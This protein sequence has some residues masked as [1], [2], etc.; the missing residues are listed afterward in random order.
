MTGSV[1]LSTNSIFS[2]HQPP[3]VNYASLWTWSEGKCVNLSFWLTSL[4]SKTL[5]LKSGLWRL[6]CYADVV[7]VDDNIQWVVEMCPMKH[8]LSIKSFEI[9]QLR[10]DGIK[11]NFE[12]L[13]SSSLNE[14]CLSKAKQLYE[15]LN[16]LV[17]NLDILYQ[18]FLANVSPITKWRI[19][20]IWKG[21]EYHLRTNAV[22]V[23]L[24]LYEKANLFIKI[25]FW[26][27]LQRT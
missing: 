13:Q 17:F 7:W 16:Y 12:H 15:L 6:N 26:K 22:K 14:K 10:V 9:K 21:I 18:Y 20:L 24:W 19:L 1:F 3:A 27:F 8:I 4:L 2:F 11:T 25:D 23:H 5:I